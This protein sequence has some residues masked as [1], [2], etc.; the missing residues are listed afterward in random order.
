MFMNA[1]EEGGE[2]ESVGNRNERG[3]AVIFDNV[4]CCRQD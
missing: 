2:E 3:Q 1:L 4:Q